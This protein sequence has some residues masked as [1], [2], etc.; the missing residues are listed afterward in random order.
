MAPG[1][2]ETIPF[3]NTMKK[4]FIAAAEP[5]RSYAALH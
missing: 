5:G 4:I 3:F 1:Y 2:P